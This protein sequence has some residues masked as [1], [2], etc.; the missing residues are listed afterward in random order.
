MTLERTYNIPLRKDFQRAPK[1]KRAKKAV[2]SL[3]EFLQRHMKSEDIRIGSSL[4]EKLWV[5]GIRN[6]PHHIKVTAVKADDGTVRAELFGAVAPA[7][8]INKREQKPAPKKEAKK[9]EEKEL[10]D[11]AGIIPPTENKAAQA[12][13]KDPTKKSAK[14]RENKKQE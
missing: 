9:K 4:N 7:K 1:Y 3:K 2:N 11:E 8:K 12:A 6:P 13:Q 14:V 10:K 5:H